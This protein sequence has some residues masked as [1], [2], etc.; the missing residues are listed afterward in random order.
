M[1]RLKHSYPFFPFLSFFLP[2]LVTG[3]YVLF[4][5]IY[6]YFSKI[7]VHFVFQILVSDRQRYIN[8]FDSVSAWFVTTKSTSSFLRFLRRCFTSVVRFVIYK[9]KFQ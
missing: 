7:N 2:E 1:F 5:D 9:G 4:I 3:L 8:D 6:A